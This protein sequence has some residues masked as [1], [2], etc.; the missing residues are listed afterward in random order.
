VNDMAFGRDAWYAAT[1]EGL[2]ISRDRGLNWTGVSLAPVPPS[3]TAATTASASPVR[4]V[5]IGNPSSYLLAVTPHQLEVSGD[6]GK[7]WIARALPAETRSDLH[8]QAPD[9]HTVVL[10]G[11]HGVFV[12]HDAGESWRQANVPE[13]LIEGLAPVRSAMVVSSA[14]GALFVSR[15]GGKSWGRMDGPVAEGPLSAL[16]SRDA[17]NQLVA[18]SATEGLYVLDMGAASSA[19]GAPAGSIADAASPSR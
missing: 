13:L 1:E 19:S 3:E 16:R 11:D 15:D 5:R 2:L 4:A 18:A 9:D 10:A 8:I 7:T 17:G 12:S 6:S 14:S